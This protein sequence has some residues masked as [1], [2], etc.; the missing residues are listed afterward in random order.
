[1]KKEYQ[2]PSVIV[3]EAIEEASL[4]TVSSTDVNVLDEKAQEG[5]YG[6]S[7][8]YDLDFDSE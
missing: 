8:I 7:P 5:E 4:L 2:S 6:L 1:M 3:I